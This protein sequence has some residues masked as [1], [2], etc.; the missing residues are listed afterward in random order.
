MMLEI[1]NIH[2]MQKSI[3]VNLI[4]W[5]LSITNLIAT[6]KQIKLIG[7]KICK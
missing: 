3:Q 2:D 1:Q 7:W 5:A 6:K 4:F